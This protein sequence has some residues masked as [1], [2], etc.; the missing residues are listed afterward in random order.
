M[1]VVVLDAARGGVVNIDEFEEICSFSPIVEPV[2]RKTLND[3]VITLLWK[4]NSHIRHSSRKKKISTSLKKKSEPVRTQ[5]RRAPMVK[6]KLNVVD[7]DE[8][9]ELPEAAPVVER[10]VL[11]PKKA[12]VTHGPGKGMMTGGLLA[13]S[14]RAEAARLEREKLREEEKKKEAEMLAGYNF[15]SDAWYASDQ[16]NR[17]LNTQ[18]GELVS[19]SNRSK[20]AR[21]KAEQEAAKF[22]DLLDHSQRMNDELI[23]EQ[24]VL[25]SKVGALTSALAEADKAK[26]SEAKKRAKD[27]LRRSLEIMEARSRDQTEVSRLAL[28]AIQVVGAIRRMDKAAKEGV[29]VDVAKKEKLEARLA[30]YNAEADRI[31]LP[32]IPEDS[33]DDEGVE[34][35]PNLALDISSAESSEDEAERTEVDG[36]MTVAGKTPALNRAEIEEATI[37]DTH[38]GMDRLEFQ[39]GDD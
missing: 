5:L 19:E 12:P 20:K 38:D 28:L 7:S 9:L 32:F 26:K 4:D 23:A 24:D 25:I 22:K 13:N 10:E 31:I 30:A 34:L 27:K 17:M 14:R 21:C 8:E 6:L 3:S 37:S 18:N 33:S 11:R 39:G 1:A 2:K 15:L 36:Q 16:K 29:P 35:T